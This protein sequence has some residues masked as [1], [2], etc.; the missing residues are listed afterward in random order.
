MPTTFS[1]G[2]TFDM[3]D[4]HLDTPLLGDNKVYTYGDTEEVDPLTTI[5]KFVHPVR[6]GKGT[7]KP[8]VGR[9]N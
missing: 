3:D 6:S 8:L 7:L 5:Q 2:V 1:Y 4:H 9:G